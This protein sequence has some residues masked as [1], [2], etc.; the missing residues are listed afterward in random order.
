[1]T[2]QHLPSQFAELEA[3]ID[4]AL[5]TERERTA[6]RHS[7]SMGAIRAFYA[8]ILP[9]LDEILTLFERFT[10]E[11]APDDINRLFLLTLSLAEITPAVEN[12]DQPGVIDGYEFSRFVPLHD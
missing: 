4:W 3:F 9:R 10:P 7:S 8:A 6:R 11:S 5:P 1:M 12:F 2:E